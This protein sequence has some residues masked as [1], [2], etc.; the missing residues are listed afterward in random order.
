MTTY[1]MVMRLCHWSDLQAVE[2]HGL[3]PPAKFDR[4]VHGEF[5]YLPVF[6]TLTE[7]EAAS[8]NGRYPVVEMIGRR[9]E[10]TNV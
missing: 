9:A 7:A 4:G 10:V 3:L 2:K 5:G 8:D 6:A 1:W